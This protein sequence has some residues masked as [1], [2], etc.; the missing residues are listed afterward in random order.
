VGYHLHAITDSINCLKEVSYEPN[1]APSIGLAMDGYPIHRQLT[2]NTDKLDNCGGHD[3]NSIGYHYHAAAP[4]ENK[5]LSC[6]TGETGCSSS[7]P[8][9]E[10]DASAQTD[11]RGGPPGGDGGK[12]PRPPR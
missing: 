11:R 3:S 6:H 9:S 5:I 8:N 2:D 7:D 4:G 10:C 1:H 12:G